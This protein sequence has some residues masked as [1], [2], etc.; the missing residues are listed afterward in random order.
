M[1][2][3]PLTLRATKEA[4]RRIQARRRIESREGEDLIVSC[5]MS[6]D[7]RSAVQSFLE[8]RSPTWTGR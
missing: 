8:K 3:A 7:F 6:H 4:I 5:Y 1:Q 2:L